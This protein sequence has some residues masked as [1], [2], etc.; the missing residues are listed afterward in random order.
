MWISPLS[1]ESSP[2]LPCLSTPIMFPPGLSHHLFL[3]TSTSTTQLQVLVTYTDFTAAW[4]LN[5]LPANFHPLSTPFFPPGATLQIC[6][7][8]NPDPQIKY[9]KEIP[10]PT[11]SWFSWPR[12]TSSLVNGFF[13]RQAWA[14]TALKGPPSFVTVQL[15]QAKKPAN[16]I[17]DFKWIWFLIWELKGTQSIGWKKT[18]PLGT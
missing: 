7:K 5:W 18:A 16:T 11:W 3:S 8:A 12:V 10:K 9:A 1:P 17:R 4:L 15:F 6:R 14:V 13:F 2:S